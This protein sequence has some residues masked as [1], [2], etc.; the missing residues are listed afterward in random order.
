MHQRRTLFIEIYQHSKGQERE[1][2]ISSP[3]QGFQNYVYKFCQKMFQ[4]EVFPKDFQ[5]TTLHMI[6]KPGKHSRREILSDSRYIH[7]KDFW[8][9][10]TEGLVVE[11]GLKTPLIDGSSI[12]QIGGQ[13]GHRSEEL[14]F[15]VKSVM[16][17]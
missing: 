13:P 11:D 14:V 10:A 2:M 6:F 16:S 8:V 17:K 4:E 15:V 1:I 12:Y 3:N 7:S 5:N 9:R